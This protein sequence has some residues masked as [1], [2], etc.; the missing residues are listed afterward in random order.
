MPASMTIA[1]VASRPKVTGSRIEMPA[2][3]PMPGSMPTRVPTRQPRKA[4]SSTCGWKATENPSAR[5][6]STS[7][8]VLD[9][10]SFYP[11]VFFF[12]RSRSK[13]GSE[14][15]QRIHEGVA[16]QAVQHALSLTAARYQA[17]VL[18]HR[19]V[20]RHRRRADAEARRE[21]AGGERGLRQRGEDGAALPG[22]E[23]GENAFRIHAAPY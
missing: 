17:G 1:R 23:R 4:Y 16:H 10:L 6:S 14:P 11:D 19:K 2:S 12:L 20:A 3:G 7:M 21:L 8:A 15:R 22:G 9:G 5:L 18:Q 13:L